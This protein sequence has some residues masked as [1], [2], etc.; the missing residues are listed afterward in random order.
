MRKTRKLR[1]GTPSEMPFFTERTKDINEIS[2]VPLAIY[3]SWTTNMVPPKMKECMHKLIKMNPEFQHYLYSHERCLQFI[4]ENFDKSVADAYISLKPGAYKSDLWRYCIMYTLGGVYLDAKFYTTVPLI[5]LIKEHNEIFIV[6]IVANHTSNSDLRCKRN[7]ALYNGFL[8]SRPRNPVFKWCIENIVHNCKLKVYKNSMLSITGPCLLGEMV[9]KHKSQAYI[10]KLPF[11]FM[12]TEEKGV[13]MGMIEYKN[14]KIIG[15]YPEYRDEMGESKIK[16]YSDSWKER[17][18]FQRNSTRHAGNLKDITLVILTWKSPKTLKN[19]LDSYKKNGLIDMVTPM[20]YF[21]ERTAADDELAKKYGIDRVLG[22][23]ENVGVLKAF[24]DIVKHVKTRYF[25]LAEVDFMLV[26]NE[27]KTRK[28]LDDC[29][30]LMKEEDV[31]YVRL[32]DRKNPGKP[33]HS[34]IMIPVDDSELEN[35]DYNGYI[36]LAEIVHFIEHPDKKVPDVFKKLQP[37]AYNYNWY[38][39]DFKDYHWSTNAYMADTK[40]LREVILPILKKHAKTDDKYNGIEMIMWVNTNNNDKLHG[41]KLATGEGLFKHI[42]LDNCVAH[43]D[44]A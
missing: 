5:S 24:I 22:T 33:L 21:Q 14:K 6:D 9:K 8:V 26:N 16:H 10:D 4:K 28:V 30:K 3:Q 44:K 13:T 35:Y 31:K 39:C 20:I 11:E 43:C 12:G 40:F 2:G 38:T 27:A 15:Q 42:R 36:H 1:G 19:T 7:T 25:I 29:I 34:R 23:S 41:Y 18:V 17:N 32:R 37:P